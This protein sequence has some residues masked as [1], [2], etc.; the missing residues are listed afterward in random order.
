MKEVVVL[1][2]CFVM[3]SCTQG[4]DYQITGTWKGGEGNMIYLKK[5]IEGDSTCVVDSAVVTP[6]SSFRL[7]GS[8]DEIQKMLLTYKGDK[9]KE[10][11]VAGEPLEVIF[12]EVTSEKDGKKVTSLNVTCN[13]GVEQ[14]VFDEGKDLKLTLSLMQ[15]GKMFAA[16]KVDYN[17]QVAVDS[18]SRMLHLLDS[19]LHVSVANYMDSARNNYASTYFFESYLMDNYSFD[20][21]SGFYNNLTDRVKQSSVGINLK[22]KLDEMGMVSVGGIAP[23]FKAQTPEGKELSLYDLRGHIVLLD[24][25]ASWCG[26]CM[27]E[28][29][30]VKE[31]YKK[32][33]DKGLEILGVSL[34]SKKDAWVKAIQQNELNWNHVSTLSKFD[35]PIAKRF[36]VTG[37]PRMYILDQEGKIVA[38]DLRGEALKEKMASLFGNEI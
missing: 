22:K 13:G 3:F 25:W 35:C 36:R 28:M 21:V 34:D 29:P 7:K 27:A 6:N 32:Y 17:D 14:K 33:H 9:E 26:P 4:V 38:Q 19:S 5:I 18:V 1:V 12:E 37:I 10:I 31:I 11:I 15:L 2:C 16:S 23:N 30:N 20:E 8:V 24:F